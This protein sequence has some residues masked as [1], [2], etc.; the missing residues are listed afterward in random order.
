MEE[1][2]QNRFLAFLVQVGRILGAIRQVFRS[3]YVRYL[4][5]EVRRLQ[6]ENGAL[7]RSIWSNAGTRPPADLPAPGEGAAPRP[8]PDMPTV[9]GGRSWQQVARDRER[10]DHEEFVAGVTEQLKQR[11]E[12]ANRTAAIQRER[13]IQHAATSPLAE[14]VA[15]RNGSG[16][17]AV[18]PAVRPPRDH[19]PE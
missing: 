12:R 19:V 2:R 11:A 3:R 5:A 8:K 7:W 4:E 17:N 14:P 10:K 13:E 9:R 15:G 18:E 1:L 6:A 16:A